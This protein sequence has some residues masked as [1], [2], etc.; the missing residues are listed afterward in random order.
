M[1]FCLFLLNFQYIIKHETYMLYQNEKKEKNGNE[2][3]GEQ[4]TILL[5]NFT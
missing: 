4:R 3:N 5:I 1:F 2:T